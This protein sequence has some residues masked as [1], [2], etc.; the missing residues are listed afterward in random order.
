MAISGVPGRMIIF[1]RTAIHAFHLRPSLV[2]GEY[3]YVEDTT[4]AFL[5]LELQSTT[6]LR[7]HQIQV[8]NIDRYDRHLTLCRH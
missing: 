5:G 6:K 4:I 7:E 3:M 1:P 2:I 8:R